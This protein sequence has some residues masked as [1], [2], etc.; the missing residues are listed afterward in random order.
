MIRLCLTVLLTL[1][2][3]KN[4][5]SI[6]F[7]D[8]AEGVQQSYSTLSAVPARDDPGW[9][10]YNDILQADG[11]TF[12]VRRD[13]VLE[14]AAAEVMHNPVALAMRL[15]GVYD[16]Y[17]DGVLIGSN[18]FQGKTASQFS[19]VMIP[20][21]GLT[22]GKHT[23][24]LRIT[25]LGLSA[26]DDLKLGMMVA[27]VSSG[28]LGVHH[29]VIST[30]LVSTAAFLV[31]LYLIVIWR[32]S[33]APSGIGSA[34]I[35]SVAAGVL[36]LLAQSQYLFSYS[37]FWQPVIDTLLPIVALMLSLTLPWFVFTRLEIKRRMVWMAITP[38][39]LLLTLPELWG[40]EHDVR[41]LVLLCLSL[42]ALSLFQW[43]SG[44]KQARF[45]AV[46]MA[47]ALVTLIL[48]PIDIHLF[49]AFCTLMVAV[50]LAVTIRRQARDAF[51]SAL[52]AER[53]KSDLIK[54][55]IQPHFLMNSLTALMEWVETTPK[56]AVTF[57]YRLA[58]EFRLLS[59]FAERDKVTLAEE[60]QLC[61][62]HTRLMAMRLDA[63]LVFETSGINEGMNVPPAIFHTLLENAFS[64]NNYA[65]RSIKFALE[66]EDSS[67][68][69]LYRFLCPV[70]GNRLSLGTG[71][72]TRYVRA[73]LAEFC[74]KAF[75]F[76]SEQVGSNW[77]TTIQMMGVR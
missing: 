74:G 45:F 12:W 50:D 53:L 32:T 69:T 6:D 4:A 37:Y 64:H 54:R 75:T 48:D 30:F 71:T 49:L 62:A 56:T 46:G 7:I 10:L 42:L 21:S 65:G 11:A 57:I 5:A 34:L 60:I 22:P 61:E 13:L 72:G 16:F 63:D 18:R 14:L 58:E 15:N 39:G 9:Q 40:L 77:V 17:W 70:V 35:T 38:V 28:F 36:I 51:D 33:G 25:A 27:S 31:S 29:T 66:V 3:A 8:T 19:R 1:V 24:T 73:R 26:G 41:F 68:G 47:L 76:K 55:N 59:T 20:L 52:R 43:R 44:V 67:E 23:M 2:F